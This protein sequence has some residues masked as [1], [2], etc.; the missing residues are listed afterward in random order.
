MVKLEMTVIL[1]SCYQFVQVFDWFAIFNSYS[2]MRILKLIFLDN[3]Q[4]SLCKLN[5]VTWFKM[6]HSRKCV[7]NGWFPLCNIYK[8]LTIAAL[9]DIIY[10]VEQLGFANDGEE[11]ALHLLH[12]G[13]QHNTTQ[14]LYH[15]STEDTF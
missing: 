3:F 7:V 5:S 13:H 1:G 14:P 2:G 11:A 8:N 9:E 10:D 15:T 12:T 6:P 4:T